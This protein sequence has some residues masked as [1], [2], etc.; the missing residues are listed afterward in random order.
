MTA[1]RALLALVL[2]SSAPAQTPHPVPEDPRWL[3]FEG[4]EGPGAGK[5]VVLIAADQEYRSEESLPML[6]H[7]LAERHGFH[8]TVLFGHNP[9]GLVDPTRKIRWEVKGIEHDIPGLEHLATAD[10]LVFFTRLITLPEEQQAQLRTYFDSGKPLITFRTANHAFI[11]FDY[12]VDG[13]Q[14]RFGDDVLGGAF[15]GHHGRW[16]AD[17]TR[18]TVIPEQKDHPVV[19]GVADVWGPS[20]V[21]RTYPEGESLPE[22]CTALVMGQPLTGRQPTDGPNTKLIALPVA[23]VKTWTG[24]SGK[25]ARVFHSTMGSAKDFES[26]GM[27]R[28]AVNAV[29]WGL[30]LEDQLRAD[31]DVD[32]VAPYA[33]RASG[34]DYPKLGV[35]ARPATAFDPRRA[36]KDDE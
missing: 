31:A 30:K 16:H 22:G 34:F 2:L 15:R 21:Y 11:E 35:Q 6:A 33:P 12:Q 25:P 17:S 27:R 13:K 3:V 18:G 9:E 10:A 5:H 4:G 36:P 1:M 26:A 14:V 32:P 23:W 7:L 24:A 28:L 8:A 20:D 29:Y 19:R